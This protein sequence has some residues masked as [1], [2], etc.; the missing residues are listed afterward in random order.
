MGRDMDSG[1]LITGFIVVVVLAIGVTI[2]TLQYRKMLREAKNY[3]RGLKMVPLLIHLPPSSEDIDGA[4]RDQR[5]LTEEILS[6]AQVMYNI[7]SSTATKGFK[8][9]LYGQRHLSFEII[10]RGGLVHYYA[11]V[12]TVLVDVIRQAIAAAYP[13]ARLEEVADTNVFS[14]IGKMSGTIYKTAAYRRKACGAYY[15]KMADHGRIE[16]GKRSG[17]C[18]CFNAERRPG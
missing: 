8:S 5:D 11:V 13:A 17:T 15:G 16:R 2:V 18:R 4:S 9:R 10:A 6:Q 12:P 14:K 1:P 3:E 7:I